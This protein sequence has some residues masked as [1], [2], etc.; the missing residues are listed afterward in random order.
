MYLPEYIKMVITQLVINVFLMKL[1]PLY[2]AHIELFI[3]AKSSTLMKNP[4]WS[5]LSYPVT[6]THT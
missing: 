5:L 1:A 3:H 2:S 4:K 6:S